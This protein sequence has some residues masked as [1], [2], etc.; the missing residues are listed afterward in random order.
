MYQGVILDLTHPMPLDSWSRWSSV[1]GSDVSR[2]NVYAVGCGFLFP[3][4]GAASPF[5]FIGVGNSSSVYL[6]SCFFDSGKTYTEG[7]F[8]KIYNSAVLSFT[9]VGAGR[10]DGKP[11]A[12]STLGYHAT[13]PAADWG[14]LIQGYRRYESGNVMANTD[15]GL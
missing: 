14:R 3:E 1:H 5:N 15:I 7:A 12:N 13:N 11:V 8:A 6:D 4:S 9:V 2:G 10:A